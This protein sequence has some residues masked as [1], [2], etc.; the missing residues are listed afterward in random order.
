VGLDRHRPC[1]CL[2][3][4]LHAQ[5]E[6]HRVIERGGFLKLP[7]CTSRHAQSQYKYRTLKDLS[8]DPISIWAPVG[9]A[10]LDRNLR[11]V[12]V[13]ERIA[14]MKNIPVQDHI[15]RSVAEVLPDAFPQV[16][17]ALRRVLAGESIS[18]IEFRIPNSSQADGTAPY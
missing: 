6:S 18:A 1:G 9:L 15:G 12:R 11:Y 14:A 13:N 5:E 17:H 7:I 8:I 16:E 4:L 10:F 2:E 3:Q